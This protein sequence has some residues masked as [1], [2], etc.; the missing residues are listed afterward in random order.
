[1]NYDRIRSNSKQ[2][3]ALTGFEPSEFD[4]LLAPFS[5]AY[6]AYHRKYDSRGKLRA[7]G[8]RSA[9]TER[10]PLAKV[11]IKLFFILYYLKTHPLEE[12]LAAGFEMDQPQAN[13][14]KKKLLH[15]L[16][17]VLQ[18]E[19]FSPSRSSKEL[20]E[21]LQAEEIAQV[22]LDGTER[23]VNR[24]VDDQT[25]EEHFS[26]KKK[27]HTLI[28]NVVSDFSD[29]ILYLSQTYEGK[30]HEMGI[31]RE[32]A[33]IFPPETTLWE[34][35]GFLGHSPQGA[36]TM[37]PYKKPR[38][39]KLTHEQKWFNQSISRVRVWVEHAI[40]G[41]KRLRIVKETL[42]CINLSYRDQL[43]EIACGLHNFRIFKRPAKKM[44][45]LFSQLACPIDSS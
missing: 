42:R 34:D 41:V 33:L 21:V 15:I 32:E 5:E 37:I 20:Y 17:Q 43:M 25:Q 3:L 18:T 44:P 36:Q 27:E 2:F 38:K 24:S 39:G 10:G 19:G 9:A 26:G 40:S 8:A 4:D 29:R 14:W 12:A 7:L 11:E 30:S 45:Q 13:K 31:L 28:N 6:A 1:M 35:L 23:R 16:Q 22:L